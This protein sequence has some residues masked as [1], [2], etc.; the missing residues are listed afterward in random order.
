MNSSNDIEQIFQAHMEHVLGKKSYQRRIEDKIFRKGERKTEFGTRDHILLGMCGP[1]QVYIRENVHFTYGEIIGLAGDFYG[2]P[3]E[4]QQGEEKDIRAILALYGP[5][6]PGGLQLPERLHDLAKNKWRYA[7]LALLN[8]DHFRE[9]SIAAYRLWHNRALAVAQEANRL[10]ERLKDGNGDINQADKK[11]VE[12]KVH[13][14]YFLNGFADH[15][16]TD[17]FASGHM[18][19]PRKE[20][21]WE[22]WKAKEMHDEEN[23]YGLW[24]RSDKHPDA[25]LAFGDDSLDKPEAQVHLERTEQAVRAS[26]QDINDALAGQPVVQEWKTLIPQPLAARPKIKPTSAEWKQTPPQFN[27]KPLYSVDAHGKICK[28]R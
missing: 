13:E 3:E 11:L 10:W 18:R 5:D 6:Q 22:P 15:F 27:Y 20:L 26:L 14:A 21:Q 12:A 23:Q 17:S 25:W 7:K 2:T 24:V 1:E 19:V 4:L 16:W 8:F 28:R 9:E